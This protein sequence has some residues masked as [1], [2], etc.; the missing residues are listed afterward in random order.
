MVYSNVWIYEWKKSKK[1]FDLHEIVMKHFSV[2]E[3]HDELQKCDNPCIEKVCANL[4]WKIIKILVWV[5][6]VSQK[7]RFL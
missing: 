4:L 5:S 1:K 7:D 3:K 6:L 2:V